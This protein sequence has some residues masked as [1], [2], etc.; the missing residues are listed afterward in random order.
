[1]IYHWAPTDPLFM[2]IWLKQ[3]DLVYTMYILVQRSHK[4]GSNAGPALRL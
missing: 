4:R 2:V 3:I 1:M